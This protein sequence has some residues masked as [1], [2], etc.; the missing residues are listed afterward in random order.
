MRLPIQVLKEIGKKYDYSIV[1]VYAY[2]ETRK[3]QHV[4]SWGKQLLFAIR[5]HNGL[6]N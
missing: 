6:I 1:V 2:D 4:A 5:Q 3:I